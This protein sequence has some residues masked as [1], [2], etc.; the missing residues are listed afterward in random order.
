V[1]EHSLERESTWSAARHSLAAILGLVLIACGSDAGESPSAAGNAGSGGGA[2]RGSGGNNGGDASTTGGMGGDAG[3]G[4]GGTGSSG[5]S[6]GGT[7]GNGGAD[8]GGGGTGGSG[9]S[10]GGTG[11]RG[12]SSGAGGAPGTKCTGK[13][14][15]PGLKARNVGGRNVLVHIPPTVNPNTGVPLLLVHHGYTMTGEAMRTLTGFQAI[16][17]RE[18]FVVAFPDGVGN[19]WNVGTGACG[20]GALGSGTADDFTFVDALISSIEA[21]QCLS[22]EHVFMT[23]FSMGGY[24]SNHAGCKKS[25]VIR[26]IAPHSGGTYPGSCSGGPIPVMIWH[27]SADFL[28]DSNCGRNARDVWVERNGCQPTFDT[29]PL[30]M[31]TCEWY[32]GC[33]PGGQVVLCMMNGMSHQW[34]GGAAPIGAPAYENASEMIWKFFK[35]QSGP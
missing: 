14:G 18:G 28:I 20:G 1:R 24:F 30:T 15:A 35:E 12:G 29:V 5:D 2:G 16:A 11:G 7:A 21:D 27:G 32:K 26:A 3:S 4:G 13:P 8:D 19:T 22:R 34:S 10:G 25:N 6:S 9:D 17:D 31:G 33:P 23:G